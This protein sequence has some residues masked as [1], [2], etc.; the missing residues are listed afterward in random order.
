MEF[1]G[2]IFSKVKEIRNLQF[3]AVECFWEL[4][5]FSGGAPKQFIKGIRRVIRKF[6]LGGFVSLI[7][8]ELQ[9]AYIICVWVL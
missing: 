2:R 7:A 6:R 4:H 5:P 8:K 3:S 9:Q 1:F